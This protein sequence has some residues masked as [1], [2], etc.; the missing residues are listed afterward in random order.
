MTVE[1]EH[2]DT[3]HRVEELAR[4]HGQ[5]L[6]ALAYVLTGD[7]EDAQDCVQ[8]VLLRLLKRGVA[9][10]K[11]DLPRYARKAVVN[12]FIDRNRARV[13]LRRALV[14]MRATPLGHLEDQPDTQLAERDRIVRALRSLP[15][16]ARAMLVLRYYGGLHDAEIAEV[17]ECAPGTV[18]SQISRAMPKLRAQL[19]E[20][21]DALDLEKEE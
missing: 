12:E 17:L 9:E 15:T 20:P 21:S 16:R 11:I 14:L 10:P 3:V 5:A 19:G 7:A 1:L 6:V 18:R 13:R 8:S 2:P 4:D